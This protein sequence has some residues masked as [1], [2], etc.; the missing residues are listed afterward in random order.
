M[1]DEL[2]RLRQLTETLTGNGYLKDQA[3]EWEYALDAI[4]ECIYIINNKFEIKFTDN[5]YLDNL[6]NK[7]NSEVKAKMSVI[8]K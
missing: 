4:P 6:R 2:K 3:K 5:L 7:V 8:N 1:I